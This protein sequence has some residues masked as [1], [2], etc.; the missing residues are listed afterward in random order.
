PVVAG[1]SLLARFEQTERALLRAHRI[2]R[3]A[4]RQGEPFGA[5]AEWFLDNF[6]IITDALREVHTDLPGGYY[7][8]LPKLVDGPLAGCP[9][10]YALALELIAHCDSCLDEAN[11][12]QFVRAY[13]SVTPLTI[14]ELWAVPI[15]LRVGLL[16]NLLRLAGQI[17]EAR[18]HRREARS[19][20][21]R[22]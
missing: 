21:P 19:W 18:V 22:C 12:T 6:H 11:N 5:D 10:V 2:I 4:Y 20:V 3:D 15:M 9:R 16:D 13:Q 17:V 14:G 8:L 1:T 7:E